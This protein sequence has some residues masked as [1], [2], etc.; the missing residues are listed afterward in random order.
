MASVFWQFMS[1]VCQTLNRRQVCPIF[2]QRCEKKLLITRIQK[3]ISFE[4]FANFR[5]AIYNVKTDIE[6]FIASFLRPFTY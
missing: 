4:K 2:C 5:H 6:R 3:V 1:D